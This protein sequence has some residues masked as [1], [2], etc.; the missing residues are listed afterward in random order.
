[1]A[2]A[3]T[4][5][6]LLTGDMAGLEAALQRAEKGME[7]TAARLRSVGATLALTVTTSLAAIGGGALA[8]SISFEQ[9]VAQMAK[10]IDAT[11]ETIQGL[12]SGFT[13]LSE[14]IPVA[15]N[16]LAL[17]AAE[18]GQLGIAV[19]SIPSFTRT[20]ADLRVA[21]NLG[22]AAGTTLA[23]LANIMGDVAP[24]FDRMGAT[25][26]DLGNNSA[27]TERE[28]A[29]MALRVAGAGKVIGLHH[30]EVLALAAALSSVGI[31]AEA[32]GTAISR[33][34]VEIANSVASGGDK[35]TKFAQVAG[36]TSAE[37]KQAFQE[38]AAT[39]V[40][41][42]IEGLGRLNDAG[43]NV[44]A[45]LEDVEFQNV[46]IRDA[47]LRAAGAGDL[48]RR[49]L[50]LGR[51]AWQENTAL[52]AEAGR[53]YET[54][55]NQLVI[56]RNRIN[57]VAGE[58]G[59][60]LVPA[61]IA[62]VDAA[63][64]VIEMVRAAIRMF[65]TLPRPIQTT[66]I[67]TGALVALLGPLALGLSAAAS[68]AGALA[69]VGAKLTGGLI[70]L[71][72][73]LGVGGLVFSVRSFA[74]AATVAKWS[75]SGLASMVTP[76]GALL[77][78]L[79]LLA[80]LLVRTKYAALQAADALEAAK[81]EIAAGIGQ[82]L[83]PDVAFK[84][85]N[86]AS[87]AVEQYQNQLA[88]AKATLEEMEGNRQ[89]DFASGSRAGYSQLEIDAQKKAVAELERKLALEEAREEALGRQTMML[90]AQEAAQ[91][92]LLAGANAP[93]PGF[94]FGTDTEERAKRIK[95]VHDELAASLRAAAGMESLLG[96]GFD[97]NRAK[98]SA[99]RSALQ[100]LLE[101]GVS[102]LSPELLA[103]ASALGVVETSI[104]AADDAEK[105]AQETKR[106]RDR[107]QSDALAIVQQ[108]MTAQEKYEQQT[109]R[110]KEALDASLI[111]QQDYNR[112]VAH[113]DEELRKASKTLADTLKE[114][115]YYAGESLI[116]GILSGARNMGDILKSAFINLALTYI[117]G[118]VRRA[119]GIA[120]PSKVFRGYGEAIGEGLA[121]GIQ[122][123]SGMVGRAS[124]M[125]AAAVRVPSLTPAYSL[126]TP[127][128]GTAGLAGA[129]STLAPDLS[130]LPK[131]V[132]PLQAARDADWLRM[133]SES[134]L[135][136]ATAGHRP[137]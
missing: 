90:Q 109:R 61:L 44:F 86:E 6:V 77:V 95:Q 136:L 40:V 114:Q 73:I 67:A 126:N 102:P 122:S 31:Q 89:L 47:L 11:D 94:D 85:W 111:S 65:A 88:A 110:L 50:D 23:R 58:L 100:A 107:L 7:G 70:A 62:A 74:D 117:M 60:V 21:T 131:A 133:L 75:L 22:E 72:G 1:M 118:P 96:S 98:A 116:R 37:F 45:V 38:D 124:D 129:A 91:N 127:A 39:A 123:S 57:N 103:Y 82:I 25:I 66:V 17:I 79:G 52:V 51:N 5:E 112:A 19:E 55:Q 68:A 54:T 12:A 29:D 3:G 33:V 120:S 83:D 113:L 69:G 71:R 76:G 99:Y 8:S 9:S 125:L 104:K 24:E 46:R 64:P 115:G 41:S 35:L 36:M 137:R 32:G 101:E 84:Q 48:M 56:L 18:A 119:L 108:A 28:I 63:E 14:Q 42:F 34:M 132:G 87:R 13:E 10:T 2:R 135:E 106:E 49:S 26:V 30:P 130:R 134:Q 27:S 15:R 53:F 43:V 93:P 20:V 81:H 16:E 4:V 128:P 80:S 121:L 97:E 92:K 78:G 59:D 105:S